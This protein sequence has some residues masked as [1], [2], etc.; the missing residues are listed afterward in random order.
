LRLRGQVA[1]QFAVK[2]ARFA[3][4]GVK[5]P[6]HAE[7]R[8]GNHEFL[9]ERNIPDEIQEEALPAAKASYNNAKGCAFVA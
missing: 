8:L 4:A 7:V 1:H 6:L 5:P 2:A 3:A 9:L